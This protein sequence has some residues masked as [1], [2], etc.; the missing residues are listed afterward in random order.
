MLTLKNTF[1]LACAGVLFTSGLAATGLAMAVAGLFLIGLVDWTGAPQ[2]A[3]VK[4]LPGAT[5]DVRAEYATQPEPKARIF[6]PTQI[7]ERPPR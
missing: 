2:A 3:R 7:S 6:F 1:K 4:S 5:E